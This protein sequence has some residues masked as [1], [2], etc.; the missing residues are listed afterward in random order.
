M[1]TNFSIQ[2]IADIST[3]VRTY[4]KLFV[5]TRGQ[6]FRNVID[7]EE[8]VRTL[9]MI[10]DDANEHVGILE[11]SEDMVSVDK[12][13]MFGKNPKLFDSMFDKAK[14]PLTKNAEKKQHQRGRETPSNDEKETVE[15]VSTA[16]GL[17]P[18]KK[19]DVHKTFV[20]P[21]TKTV[22]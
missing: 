19:V 22:K 8:A 16:L 10:I 5:T 14:I 11:V 20:A 1:K 4:K 18:E 13:K 12:L 9:N 7:A 21:E 17:T 6:M 3:K 2:Q 15:D